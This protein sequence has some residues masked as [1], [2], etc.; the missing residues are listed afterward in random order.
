MNAVNV[1][2]GKV[3]RTRARAAHGCVS[4]Q[5]GARRSRKTRRLSPA[6]ASWLEPDG[7]GAPGPFSKWPCRL[8]RGCPVDSPAVVLGAVPWVVP[9]WSRG[10]SPG[11]SRGGPA[12]VL[13]FRIRAHRHLIACRAGRM[14]R[15]QRTLKCT[16]TCKHGNTNNHQTHLTRTVP[17]Q[18]VSTP[19]AARHCDMITTTSTA[20][21][22]CLPPLP[23]HRKLKCPHFGPAAQPRQF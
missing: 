12:G 14:R 22:T 13:W 17:G 6:S 21:C 19:K 2:L 11:S 8:S 5:R 18:K 1:L 20:W 9:W 7:G 15:H 23:P 10:L 3:R 4:K 16:R